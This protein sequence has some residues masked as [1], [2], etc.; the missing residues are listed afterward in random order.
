MH[1]T[2]SEESNRAIG[3]NIFKLKSINLVFNLTTWHVECN[4]PIYNF[5]D[6]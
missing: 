1:R 6:V 5:K 3:D 4:I 2:L